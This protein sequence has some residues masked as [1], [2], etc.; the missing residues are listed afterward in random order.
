MKRLLGYITKGPA[1]IVAPSPGLDSG[2]HSVDDKYLVISTDPCIDVPVNLFGWLL[3][4]YAAS[5]V[6]LSGA[7]PQYCTINLLGSPSTSSKVIFRVMDQACRAADEIGMQIVTGHTGTYR[8]LSTLVG[9]C[10]AYGIIEK[11]NLI[12][13]GGAVDGDCILCTRN[14]GFEIAVNLSLVNEP[15]SNNLFGKKVTERLQKSTKTQSCVKDALLLGNTN[16]VHALHDA[17]EGGLVAALNEIAEAS[18]VGFT[19]DSE[20]LPFAE[21][22]QFL[23][24]YFLLSETEVLS[25]SST[26]TVIAAI[27]PESK[28]T[29]LE[30]LRKHGVKAS[31]IGKFTKDTK[32]IIVKNKRES[33]FP[34]KERDPYERILSWDDS[35]RA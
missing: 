10:T 13:A 18:S 15:L 32:R 28:P 22:T 29:V 5:D 34:K 12:T 35:K 33:G 20:M 27:S 4:N 3:I 9:V 16:G 19:I 8:G 17:T 1:L 24:G 21:E 26:G 25:M 23:R 14:L 2:V 7:H 31:V 6:A 11:K 30:E